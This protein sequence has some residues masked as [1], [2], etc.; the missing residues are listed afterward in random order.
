M[1]RYV[2]C[3]R[4]RDRVSFRLSVTFPTRS[5]HISSTLSRYLDLQDRGEI[6]DNPYDACPTPEV[7]I[8]HGIYIC[9]PTFCLLLTLFMTE[10]DAG[11]MAYNLSER[12]LMR[13]GSKHAAYGVVAPA[14]AAALPEAVPVVASPPIAHMRYPSPQP[15][16]A[17]PH[18]RYVAWNAQSPL[19]HQ[20]HNGGAFPPNTPNGGAP[21]A[22]DAGGTMTQSPLAG[23]A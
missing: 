20:Q 11:V 22:P 16:P 23:S 4:R 15:T 8:E 17:V 2:L 19:H 9:N 5:I 14:A 10:T 7:R 18:Q 12:R 1:Y 6:P 21:P 3:H 13:F